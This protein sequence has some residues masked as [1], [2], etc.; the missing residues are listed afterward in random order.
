MKYTKVQNPN[1]IRN[2][3]VLECHK[4]GF[5]EKKL[6]MHGAGPQVSL[7]YLEPGQLQPLD[8]RGLVLAR[9]G[10][11]LVAATWHNS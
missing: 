8:S 4:E 5:E 6:Q 2:P 10:P 7:V 3:P 11:D 9:L 1:H